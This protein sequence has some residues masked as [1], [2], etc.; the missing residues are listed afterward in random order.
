LTF[1]LLKSNRGRITKVEDFVNA[2][3]V[4]QLPLIEKKKY[5]YPTSIG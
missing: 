4:E 1:A 5:S 2:R 3:I